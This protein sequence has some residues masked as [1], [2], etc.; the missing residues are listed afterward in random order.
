MSSWLS[1]S[2][3]CT[4]CEERKPSKKC[5]NG[6]R[7]SSVAEWQ[8][9]D[10]SMTSW[11]LPDAIIAQPQE[12]VAMTSEW[13]PKIDSAC[14]ASARADTWNTVE[15]SSPAI[16][17]MFGIMSSSPCDAVNVVVRAPAWSAPCTEPDAP[18]SDWSSTTF[19][20]VP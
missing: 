5:R 17:N 11:M 16:L 12:R 20:M 13:S 1:S 8:M 3:F 14:T 7:A 15:V 9:S 4:S 6:R 2:I 19:G 10:R 18:P